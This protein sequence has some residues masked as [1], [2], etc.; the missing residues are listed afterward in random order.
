MPRNTGMLWLFTEG[1]R[2]ID[3]TEKGACVSQGSLKP[4]ALAVAKP[5]SAYPFFLSP[6]KCDWR[7]SHVFSP[8]PSCEMQLPRVNPDFPTHIAGREI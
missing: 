7:R 2:P 4:P 3:S 6:Q 5:G 1:S 8:R